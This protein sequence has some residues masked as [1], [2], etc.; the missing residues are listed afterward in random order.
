VEI[1]TTQQE[2]LVIYV[3]EEQQA[4]WLFASLMEA[5]AFASSR[6]K[7]CEHDFHCAFVRK[8]QD[9][10]FDTSCP[11]WPLEFGPGQEYCKRL[12]RKVYGW[13]KARDAWWNQLPGGIN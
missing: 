2:I 8:Y 11:D 5:K 1:G 12:Q 4:R 13:W 3:V 6:I 10:Q 7:E 9:D